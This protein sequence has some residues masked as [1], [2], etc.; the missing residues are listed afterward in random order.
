LDHAIN[1]AS[2]LITA[3]YVVGN[4]G[5]DKRYYLATL[6]KAIDRVQQETVDYTNPKV[7][8]LGDWIFPNAHP[9]FA[10]QI[11]PALGRQMD[12]T[13]LCGFAQKSLWENG[14]I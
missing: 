11:E 8:N 6:S 9:F 10:G 4:E 12:A 3:G 14:S 2:N 13:G 7:L 5:L 1:L